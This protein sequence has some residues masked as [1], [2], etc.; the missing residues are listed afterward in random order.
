MRILMSIS[1]RRT[2]RWSLFLVVE[3]I[4]EVLL[5]FLSMI[6]EGAVIFCRV[7]P[8]LFVAEP[9]VSLY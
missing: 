4:S 6:V 5:T 9:K 8:S 7:L 2:V 1:V 3:A